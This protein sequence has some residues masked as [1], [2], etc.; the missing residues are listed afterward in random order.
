MSLFSRLAGKPQ[1]ADEDKPMD[2]GLPQQDAAANSA[3][4]GNELDHLG[5]GDE[6]LALAANSAAPAAQRAAQQR[7]AQLIDAGSV[8]LSRL[9]GDM[10]DKVALLSVAA[11]A[12]DSAQ[13]QRAADSIADLDFFL[14][15]AIDGPSTRLRQLAAEK[16]EDP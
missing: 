11:L 2:R 9:N 4:A 10:N 6:L 14:K 13:L 5:Y 1:Q 16:I 8:D 3:S 12:R 15:L 7:L